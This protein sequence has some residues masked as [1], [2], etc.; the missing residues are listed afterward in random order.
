MTHAPPENERG[1]ILMSAIW[2]LLIAAAIVAL[3][4]LK[5]QQLSK[6]LRFEQAQAARQMAMESAVDQLVTDLF[7]APQESATPLFPFRRQYRIA[8]YVINV[9][10]R[11]EAGK[12]NVNTADPD[13]VRRGLQ[14]LNL[15]GGVA[16]K[17]ADIL[18]LSRRQN[19]SIQSLEEIDQKLL[20]AG[21]NPQTA[22]FCPRRYLTIYGSGGTPDPS[23]IPPE[24]ARALAIPR[25][26]ETVPPNNNPSVISL[27]IRSPGGP[28]I[29][30][31]I[32]PS[33]EGQ[34][35]YQFL[36]YHYGNECG[37]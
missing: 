16:A 36:H 17:F 27:E 10:A 30:A 28:P 26:S 8:G 4:A 29:F 18:S 21:F 5:E 12:L 7:G 32:T 3:V 6:S 13:L 25:P 9:I 14:G 2:L 11:D 37:A 22:G 1:Y 24:L 20:E 33:D 35:I 34:S 15:N 19:K 31:R 23:A